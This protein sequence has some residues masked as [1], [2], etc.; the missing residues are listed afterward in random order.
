MGKRSVPVPAYA[1][2][3]LIFPR[4][5]S[6]SAVRVSSFSTTDLVSKFIFA[7]RFVA[8]FPVYNSLAQN[9]A[10]INTSGQIFA[11]FSRSLFFLRLIYFYRPF[12]R[13]QRAVNMLK[14]NYK[15]FLFLR[16]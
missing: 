14:L 5:N 4:E 15:K 12:F 2:E 3:T 13:L 16:K 11:S 7:L 1:G 10:K 9:G 8:I 6:I